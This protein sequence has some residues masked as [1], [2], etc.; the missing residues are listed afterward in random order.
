MLIVSLPGMWK[1]CHSG[2]NDHIINGEVYTQASELLIT[3]KLPLNWP[4]V[5]AY[6]NEIW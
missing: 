2:R 3:Q 6:T 5:E 1:L 4:F